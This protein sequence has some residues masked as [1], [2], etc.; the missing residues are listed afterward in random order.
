MGTT[1][2]ETQIPYLLVRDPTAG[3]TSVPLTSDV[4]VAVGRAPTNRVVIH[5]ERA[6]R[7]HAEIFPTDDGWAIRD[8]QSRNGTLLGGQPLLTDRLL[9]PGDV[10][11]IGRTELVFCGG[12]QLT[13]PGRAGAAAGGLETGETGRMASDLEAW[14][15]SITHRRTRSEFLERARETAESGPRVGKAAA[16][17]CRLAFALG[18]ASD[19]AEAASIALE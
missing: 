13:V 16:E 11:S 3:Q 9:A 18:R 14:H 8:L 6:S 12:D 1:E 19:L 4:R 5:D 15:A 2:T 10:V 7:F 17:L